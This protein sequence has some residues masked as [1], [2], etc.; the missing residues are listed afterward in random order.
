M[1]KAV[2]FDLDGTLISDTT[3]E[4]PKSA[5]NAV[6]QLR[7]NG[8]KI[9]TATGRHISEIRDLPAD[10]IKFDGYITLNG[11]LCL[12]SQE[13]LLYSV[14][15]SSTDVKQILHVFEEGHVPVMLVEKDKMYISFIDEK[16]RTAQ[17]AIHTPVPDIGIYSGEPVYQ[18]NL[19]TDEK[20]AEDIVA[21]LSDCKMSRW[22][23]YA[24]DIISKSGGK[25]AG[26]R[27]IMRHYGIQ[28]NE[29]MAFG[30]GENDMDMLRYAGIGVAMGNADR[31][32]KE[33]ADYITEHVDADGME[34]ALKH[35]YM[36]YS[37]LFPS[38][39]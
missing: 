2:F 34:N 36:S 3:G 32:V 30:D 25:V 15:V 22:N 31:E 23:P 5:R 8:V 16:V 19:F 33:C 6:D 35:Y 11:Q 17:A 13:E 4:I 20:T 18:C 7:K 12:D 9:F 37:P 27:Q 28:Q 10:D 39:F 1:I 14:P 29:I 26:I 38:R 21:R 24:V